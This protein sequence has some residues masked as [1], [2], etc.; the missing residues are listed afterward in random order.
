MAS[1][2]QNTRKRGPRSDTPEPQKAPPGTRWDEQTAQTEPPRAKKAP[3]T[4]RR[5]PG[6]PQQGALRAHKT[7]MGIR[8]NEPASPNSRAG[9][10]TQAAGKSGLTKPSRKS[11][12]SGRTFETLPKGPSRPLKAS[13]KATRN[14]GT[15]VYIYLYV[16]IYVYI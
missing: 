8:R 13:H 9:K 12:G 1:R 16:F 11:P 2:A 5:A 3:G 15:Y 6:R 10:T 7:G 4:T 14:R